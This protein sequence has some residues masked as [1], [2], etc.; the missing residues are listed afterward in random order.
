MGWYGEGV[1]EYEVGWVF[2]M[3]FVI[4][5]WFGGWWVEDLLWKVYGEG[6]RCMFSRE[7][8]VVGCFVWLLLLQRLCC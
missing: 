2:V 3:M 6:V 8:V 1:F 5:R 7:Y 4:G